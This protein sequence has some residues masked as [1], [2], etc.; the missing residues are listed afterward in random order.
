MAALNT[1]WVRP[2]PRRTLNS[3]VAPTTSAPTGPTRATAASVTDELGDQADCRDATAVGVESQ[4]RNSSTRTAMVQDWL[5]GPSRSGSAPS[6]RASTATATATTAARYSQAAGESFEMRSPPDRC[7]VPVTIPAGSPS[8]RYLHPTRARARRRQPRTHPGAASVTS[9]AGG[10]ASPRA[11]QGGALAQPCRP[12]HRRQPKGN[13]IARSAQAPWRR[14]LSQ[15]GVPGAPLPL[16]DND[17]GFDLLDPDEHLLAQRVRHEVVAA[18]LMDQLFD[19]FIEAVL[20]QARPAFVEVLADLRDVRCVQ[21]TVQVGVDPVQHLGTRR[22][23]RL[24]AAHC[25]SS[26][27]PLSSPCGPAADA[28]RT[29][30]RSAA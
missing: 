23:M 25:S 13:V 27:G 28:A 4:I 10:A 29:M 22:L 1:R 12:V 19:Q 14:A 7:P 30:P 2:R 15:R 6:A 21:L 8:A 5:T 24:A 20:G 17:L 9:V 26:P 18:V 11:C 16:A 3:D